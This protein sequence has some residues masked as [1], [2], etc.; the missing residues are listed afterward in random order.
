MKTIGLRQEA[1]AGIIL[2]EILTIQ[3]VTAVT[4]AAI[5]E[6]EN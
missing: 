6:P 2:Q 1:Q 5:I 4:V 3:H